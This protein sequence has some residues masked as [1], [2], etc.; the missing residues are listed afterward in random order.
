MKKNI[1]F[2]L[3][4][5][6]FGMPAVSQ[7]L[8]LLTVDEKQGVPILIGLCSREGFDMEPFA[9]FSEEYNRYTPDMAI[10]SRLTAGDLAGVTITVI[11]GTWCSDSQREVPRFF[12][13]LDECP[14]DQ[15][16][17]ELICV[18]SAKEVPGEDIS[19]YGIE[20]VPTFIFYRDDA[21]AGRIVETPVESLEK[22]MVA[23]LLLK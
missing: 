18:N 8:N 4:I 21:E 16:K 2:C 9:W 11:L 3:F 5:I 12:R 23:I 19:V 6:L 13:I 7:S 1:I 10:L 22:D 20:R 14:F 17:I 15:S